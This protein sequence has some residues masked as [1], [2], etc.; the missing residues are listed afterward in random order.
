M[1]QQGIKI[2]Q[3]YKKIIRF[4]AIQLI[5]FFSRFYKVKRNKIVVDNFFGQ[6]FGGNPK[7][8]IEELLKKN[9]SLDIVWLT[10]PSTKLSAFPSNIRIVKYGS[11][12]AFYELG[13]ARIWI[14]NIKNNYKGRK[15]KGQFYLQTWH[16]GIGFKK[17]EK[18]TEDTL[19]NDYIRDSKHDSKQIDLMI[20]NSEWVTQNYRN[21]FWYDGKIVKTGLPRNDVF[22]NDTEKIKEKVKEFYNIDP[23]TEIILYAPTFRNYISI[24][25]QTKV[26]SFNYKKVI[27]AFENRF[28]KKFV[29]VKRMHPNVADQIPVIE[30]NNIKDG[31]RYPDMQELL[32]A[33]FALITDYSSSV[34]D[35]MLKSD[36]I[37]IFAKD[38]DNY[39][40]NERKMEFSI[41]KDLPFS[42]SNNEKELESNI[43]L[44]K[45]A[46]T[47]K[48]VNEFKKKVHLIDDGKA[49]ERVSKILIKIVNS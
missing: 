49:S 33:S 23:D 46:E 25:E 42:F 45:D 7:Y 9:P 21:N 6:G 40:L 31:S 37:F 1:K 18:A 5:D 47:Q 34:F 36:K 8:I 35:F 17:V 20:S 4:F 14:D 43:S 48:K 27:Q 39:V 2:K 44:F 3:S 24:D 10:S 41:K 13:T 19:S 26:C 12:K 30:N 16:G 38:Y 28:G 15:R 11:I 29:L 22:F 32:V